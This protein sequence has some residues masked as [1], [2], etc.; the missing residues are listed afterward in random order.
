[1]LDACRD[2]DAAVWAGGALV[3]PSVAEHLGRPALGV[4]FSTCSVPSGRHPPP[5][6]T[7][8]GQPAWVNWL[9]WWLLARVMA[10]VMAHLLA[11]PLNAQRRRL[12]LRANSLQALLFD[13]SPVVV[14]CDPVIFPPDP[15]WG[16]RMPVMGFTFLDDPAPLDPALAAWLAEG[17]PPVYVGFGKHVGAGNGARRERGG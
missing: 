11:R 16:G 5:T 6:S 7:R 2:A 4:L 10:R 8:H 13:D 1:M 14:A 15:G 9:R 3:E 12:G 17:P